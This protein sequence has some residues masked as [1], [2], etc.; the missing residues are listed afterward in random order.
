[1]FDLN[2]LE[3]FVAVVE[4]GGLTPVAARLGVPKSTLSRRISQLEERLGQPLLLRQSNRMLATEA[5]CLFHRYSRQ[6]LDLADQSRIALDEL[7]GSVSGDV[8]LNIHNAFERGWLPA[9]L[10][11]FVRE[12]PRLRLQVVPSAAPPAALQSGQADLW[13][14]LGDCSDQAMRC[15]RLGEWSVGLYASPAY[16][17]THGKPR[18]PSDLRAHA[19]FDMLRCG[20]ESLTLQHVQQSDLLAS[21]PRPTICTSSLGLQFDVIRRGQGVGV[22]PDWYAQRAEAAHPGSLV[23]CLEA[24]QAPAMPVNLLYNHGRLP[25]KLLA[26]LECLRS[27]RPVEW[28][29]VI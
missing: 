10:E 27:N 11:Q 23:R 14:W 21:T 7:R 1:M 19:W 24:W 29:V 4:E 22:L 28:A 12:H 6:M 5:G 17:Q 13:L 2:D 16:L 9:L 8:Q 18:Q 15:E 3:V 20:G 25:R 26:L